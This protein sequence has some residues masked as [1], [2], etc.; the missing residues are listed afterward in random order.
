MMNMIRIA[1]SGI[2]VAVRPS[3]R[4]YALFKVVKHRERMVYPNMKGYD[5]SLGSSGMIQRGGLPLSPATRM[6]DAM[7]GESFMFNDYPLW[8]IQSLF[9]SSNP[10]DFFGSMCPVDDD[11]SKQCRIPGLLIFSKRARAVAAWTSGAEIAYIKGIMEKREVVVECGLTTNYLLAK[12][13]K[14]LRDDVKKFE[15]GKKQ[16]SGLHFLAV[17][18]SMD[19]E[20]IEG[21]WLLRDIEIP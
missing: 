12:I 13:T 18:E 9:E 15:D 19:S 3:R 2:D 7:R 8:T 1:L 17:Q 21:F 6:P 16:A 11:V 14:D 20:E 10:D 5:K 4:T